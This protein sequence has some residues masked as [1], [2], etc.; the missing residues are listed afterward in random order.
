METLLCSHAYVEQAAL[1][2]LPQ[3]KSQLGAVITL[4]ALGRSVHQ[5]QGKLSINNA[6]KAHLLTQFERVT[7]PRR[8]RYPETL[9]LNTQGK[10]VVAQLVELFD[11]D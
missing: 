4:S 2:V 3:F 6:L 11:H 5:E 10:R 8:W 9:P 7:L 1:V